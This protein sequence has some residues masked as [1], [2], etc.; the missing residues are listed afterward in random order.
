MQADRQ[1]GGGPVLHRAW[2]FESD[3]GLVEIR[4]SWDKFVE[5]RSGA[6]RVDLVEPY[7]IEREKELTE[8]TC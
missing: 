5:L 4:V 2:I 3:E 6:I 7:D 8:C 1:E